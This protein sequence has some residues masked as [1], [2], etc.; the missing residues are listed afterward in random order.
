MCGWRNRP[1]ALS[2][3]RKTTALGSLRL[4]A[5]VATAIFISGCARQQATNAPA[6]RSQTLR[7]SQR[8]EPATLD[9]QLATLPD[10]YFIIR[11]LS[12]G[13]LVPSPDGPVNSG[14]AEKWEVSADGL[15]YTFHLRADARWSDGI[16]VTAPDFVYS[17]RRILSPKLAAAKAVHF[18]MVRGA[19][20][21]HSGLVHDFGT[22]GIRARDARTLEIVLEHPDAD[23]PAI[24]A[25]G[26]WIPVQPA[27]IERHGRIDDRGTAWTRPGNFVGNGAFALVEWSPNHEIIVRA[28]PSYW[29]AGSI[30]IQD[31]RFVAFDNGDSEER[32]FRAGQVD[33]TM[34]V[35]FSKL[36]SYADSKP[37]MLRRVP[38]F[39]TRYL[40]L[41]VH[42]HPLDDLRV[43]RALALAI[44]RR[45]LVEGVLKGGQRPAQSLVPPGLGG[46]QPATTIHEDPEM[47][48]RLLA[49]AGFPGG[50][51][52]P[53]LELTTWVNTPVLEAVQQM[54]KRELGIEM[55]IVQRDAATHIASL[56][57]SDYA[58]GMVTVI[59]DF[60]G[61][62]DVF[63]DLL[64][65]APGNFPH[66]SDPRY[67][68]LVAAAARA[69]NPGSRLE[70]L[71]KAEAT[72][73]DAMPVV[74][75]YFNA[76]NFLIQPY[77][78]NW[79]EDAL[80][81]RYYKDVSVDSPGN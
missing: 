73:L 9:P 60:A 69:G 24:V 8:N 5:T 62:S 59:P 30:H 38:L 27:A 25:S 51:G 6:G 58:I 17:A 76:K 20:S 13:L 52:F 77:V 45:A 80:W 37:R 31:I 56:Q 21:Y 81:T 42:L 29:D 16:P 75:L 50:S 64:T 48:R 36:A 26:A 14:V 67:D 47:A 72:L 43:R 15:V 23:F 74:P 4:L 68:G 35:P 55:A 78:K 7:L 18:L 71:Q 57:G 63:R 70:L 34:A 19:A 3:R 39:E 66:W 28:S 10:E 49:E 44:D 54:W 32:A 33:V 53:D 2:K 41:N 65:G 61:A 79:R 11:A 22:V 40:S 1:A 46:Y 12:E